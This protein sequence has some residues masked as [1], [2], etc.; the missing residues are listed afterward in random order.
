MGTRIMDFSTGS[1]TNNV[2]S[3]VY[4]N[5]RKHRTYTPIC[6]RILNLR[7][8]PFSPIFFFLFTKSPLS[9]D[10][11]KLHALCFV[12]IIQHTKTHRTSHQFFF[13]PSFYSIFFSDVPFQE[14][15]PFPFIKYYYSIL[16]S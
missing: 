8:A 6:P 3:N 9:M 5:N 13:L 1:K 2:D 11:I 15:F 12:T 7:E 4:V 10:P 14:N 16:F